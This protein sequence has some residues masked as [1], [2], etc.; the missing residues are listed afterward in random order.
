MNIGID[1]QTRVVVLLRVI[2]FFLS[3]FPSF[4]VVVVG[5]VGLVV[6]V[7]VGS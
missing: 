2:C 6:V 3:F 4:L 5:L 1:R 7:V